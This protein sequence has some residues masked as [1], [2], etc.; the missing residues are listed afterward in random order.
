MPGGEQPRSPRRSADTREGDSGPF[1]KPCVGRK[2]AAP[3][4]LN[5]LLLKSLDTVYSFFYKYI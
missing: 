3:T 4:G 5:W 1:L 2:G